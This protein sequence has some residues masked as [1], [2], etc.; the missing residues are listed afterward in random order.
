VI[1]AEEEAADEEEV[2]GAVV[3]VVVVAVAAV[4]VAAPG[5]MAVSG[6]AGSLVSAVDGLSVGN[7]LLGLGRGA[8][9]SAG[10]IAPDTVVVAVAAA[11]DA[12]PAVPVA[13]A[14]PLLLLPAEVVVSKESDLNG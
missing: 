4:G 10:S 2:E 6:G 5:T 11:V 9:K 8:I 3:V 13:G 7:R 1:A 14:V 12:V